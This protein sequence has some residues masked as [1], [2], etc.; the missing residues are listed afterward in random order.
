MVSISY[1][2]LLLEIPVVLA[3]LFI[4][5]KYKFKLTRNSVAFKVLAHVFVSVMV[6]MTIAIIAIG[7][8]N[9]DLIFVLCILP[10]GIIYFIFALYMIVKA[11][12]QKEQTI[13]EVIDSS[14]QASITVANIAT[15]LASSAAEVNTS[16]EEISTTTQEVT[17]YS[18]ISMK[19]SNEITEIMDL[20]TNISEQTNLLALN[21]SIEAGRAGENG[22]GFAVVADEVRKLAEES[23]AA[24]FIT[25]N[26]IKNILNNIELTFTSMEGISTSSEQQTA[27]MEEITSTA[28]RLGILA[29]QLKE[30]LVNTT[31]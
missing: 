10:P 30:Q 23:K 6:L 20:I 22:K 4:A 7:Y 1:E 27:S 14:S 9:R 29:E 3:L 2:M 24:I 5:F 31:I 8:F 19:S 11:I 16:S 28:S 26:K 18:R 25:G 15:E 21:A 17:E 12:R 13:Q